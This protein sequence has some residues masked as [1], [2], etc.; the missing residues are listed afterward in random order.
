MFSI[1][2]YHV[3]ENTGSFTQ[4][5]SENQNPEQNLSSGPGGTVPS[6]SLKRIPE[7]VMGDANSLELET[8]VVEV[9]GGKDGVHADFISCCYQ[10]EVSPLQVF[11]AEKASDVEQPQLEIA[12]VSHSGRSPTNLPLASGSV[13]RSTNERDTSPRSRS[14]QLEGIR[15]ETE[16]AIK[17]HEDTKMRLKFELEEIRAQ[18]RRNYEAKYTWECNKKQKKLWQL[19]R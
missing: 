16:Q 1:C 4:C 15:K 12:I 11:G 10:V 9:L 5:H 13:P 14:N 18:L 8:T 19:P 2:Q 7:K 6:E 17:L 3:Y